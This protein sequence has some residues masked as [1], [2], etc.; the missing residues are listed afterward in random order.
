MKISSVEQTTYYT[1][2]SY[3]ARYFILR[4][5]FTRLWLRENKLACSWNISPYHTLTHVIYIIYI[6]ICT[7]I[8]F[9]FIFCL[10][11]VPIMTVNLSI[12]ICQDHL[13]KSHSRTISET[14]QVICLIY[15][16]DFI[17]RNNHIIILMNYFFILWTTT[18]ILWMNI[19][20]ANCS[21]NIAIRCVY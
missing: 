6:Y 13:T 5:Y 3:M 21:K 20:L 12:S 15:Y 18:S 10:Y 11:L 2:Q 17:R 16:T 4:L 7:Q 14:W 8:N 19:C 1:S 9:Y